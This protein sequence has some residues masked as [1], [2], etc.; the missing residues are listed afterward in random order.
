M[1]VSGL[2]R[3]VLLLFLDLG[4]PASESL[5]LIGVKTIRSIWAG[6]SSRIG[7]DG[8]GAAGVYGL[9]KALLDVLPGV[10]TGLG[11]G[12]GYR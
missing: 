1:V 8:G 4:L 9:A 10:N 2:G 3:A 11:F 5:E 7:V 6:D 12:G